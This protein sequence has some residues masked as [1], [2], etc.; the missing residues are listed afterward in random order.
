MTKVWK[1]FIFLAILS[2][3][4]ALDQ[5]LVSSTVENATHVAMQ[6][7]DP[8]TDVSHQ[9]ASGMLNLPV[10]VVHTGFVFLMAL[11]GVILFGN[12]I[13]SLLTRKQEGA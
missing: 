9:L 7:M 13:V 6:Q 3:A 12:D 10:T 2:G 4:A 5:V 11:T 8:H 1:V